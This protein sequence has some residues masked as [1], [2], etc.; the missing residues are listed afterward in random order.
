M[1]NFL[2]LK[3]TDLL[4]FSKRAK[5]KVR[6]E[7]NLV[8]TNTLHNSTQWFEKAVSSEETRRWFERAI[9]QGG[10]VYFIVGFHTVTDVRIIFESPEGNKH[11]RRLGLP[12]GM[13]LNTVGVL[14]ICDSVGAHNEVYIIA[15]INRSFKPASSLFGGDCLLKPLCG[16]M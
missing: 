1:A 7:T 13:A 6:I 4:S 10:D 5:S 15:L 12:I 9:D 2:I 11:T 3:P 8:R 16:I 14:R